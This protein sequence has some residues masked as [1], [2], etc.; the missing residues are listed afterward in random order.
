M[1]VLHVLQP[2]WSSARLTTT[3]GVGKGR[4]LLRRAALP[5]SQSLL[6]H[7]AHHSRAALRE[8]PVRPKSLPWLQAKRGRRRRKKRTRNRQVPS[9]AL[10]RDEGSCEAGLCEEAGPQLRA[11]AMS[12]EGAAKLR[13]KPRKEPAAWSQEHRLRR[14]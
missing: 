2:L 8:E 14:Q 11:F 1:R 13:L 6:S 5:P 4:F 12:E 10:P 9:P 3:A 7:S